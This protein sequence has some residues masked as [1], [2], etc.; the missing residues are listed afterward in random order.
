MVEPDSEENTV[1]PTIE[2][3]DNRPGTRAIRRSIAPIALKATPV[4]K[5]ISP[6]NRKSG[7]GASVNLIALCT[8]IGISTSPISPLMKSA[9]PSTLAAKKANATGMPRNMA[10]HTV[11]SSKI[12]ARYHSI[13]QK[14]ESDAAVSCLA[15]IGRA[16]RRRSRN[17]TPSRKNEMANTATI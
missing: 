10:T 15:T 6:I 9:V 14:P 12:R 2:T 3:T 13:A 16:R 11:P 4:C 17:S 5:R 8:S 1:P 7:I